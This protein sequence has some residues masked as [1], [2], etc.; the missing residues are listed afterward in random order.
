MPY[1]VY[2]FRA[3]KLDPQNPMINLSIGLSYI[4]LSLKRQTENRHFQIMQG[5]SFL[6]RYYDIRK[7]SP[8]PEERQEAEYNVARA[9]HM[10]GQ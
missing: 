3:H 5:F 1:T 4:H 2:L 9:Y 10:L 6:F 7:E 8:K